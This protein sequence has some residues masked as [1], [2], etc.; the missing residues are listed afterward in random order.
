MPAPSGR[1]A[2]PPSSETRLK[3]WAVSSRSPLWG[4]N[5]ALSHP[6]PEGKLH[7]V[8]QGR[9]RPASGVTPHRVGARPAL[10]T[11]RIR[12]RRLH[13]FNK[14]RNRFRPFARHA[15]A[16]STAMGQAPALAGDRLR[17]LPARRYG[18]RKPALTAS[19]QPKL[20]S[21][22][23]SVGTEGGT[24]IAWGERV[25]KKWQDFFGG[26][27]GTNVGNV[28]CQAAHRNKARKRTF[29]VDGLN[30][31]S[32]PERTFV[33]NKMAVMKGPVSDLALVAAATGD[34]N[35][36]GR[37]LS[38]NRSK[39]CRCSHRAVEVSL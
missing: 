37:S 34:T 1:E 26:G 38:A 15:L 2:G 31:I 9:V 23:P 22:R 6:A 39:R 14:G 27:I 33:P 35:V 21:L 10:T 12:R 24:S 16:P 32:G 7:P 29:G 30:V 17:K 36:N 11:M 18:P 3:P 8:R 20:R 13:P 5:P 4:A 19:R 25:G 28:T